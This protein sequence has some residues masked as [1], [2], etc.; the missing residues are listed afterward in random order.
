[1][2]Y[3][4][5]IYVILLARER[6]NSNFQTRTLLSTLFLEQLMVDSPFLYVNRTL[7]N[8]KVIDWS[9]LCISSR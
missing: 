6:N 4:Q 1:M 9:I 3:A 2:Y 7:I 5:N 8:I